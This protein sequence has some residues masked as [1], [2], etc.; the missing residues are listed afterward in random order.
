MSRERVETV[1]A[2]YEG[3][4]TGDFRAGVDLH[5]PLIL[6]VQGEGFAEPGPY[7]GPEGV[8]R[9]MKMFLEAWERVT[10]QAEELTDAG[11]SVIAEV[12]QRAVG[13]GSGVPLAEFRYFQ[14]WTFRGDRVIRLDVI[15]ER[16]DAFAAAGVGA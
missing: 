2:I 4:S 9:F 13:R 1:R 5:D 3:W 12:T 7:V 8:R 14:V 15:R 10:I 6:L 11:D 16:D